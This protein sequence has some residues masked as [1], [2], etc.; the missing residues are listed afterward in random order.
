MFRAPKYIS[1]YIFI[2]MGCFVAFFGDI[3]FRYW[4][5]VEIGSILTAFCVGFIANL[6]SW[7]SKRPNNVVTICAIVLLVPGYISAASIGS[8]LVKDVNT[9]VNLIFDAVIACVSLVT[10]LVVSEVL[11]TKKRGRL[12]Y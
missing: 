12:A 6:Y 2:T 7:V 8:L 9:S 10:G 5:G 3:Y 11:W 4:V 1:A